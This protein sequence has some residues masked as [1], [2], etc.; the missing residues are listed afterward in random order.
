MAL[1]SGETLSQVRRN[2]QHGHPQLTTADLLGGPLPGNLV[3]AKTASDVDVIWRSWIRRPVKII[4]EYNRIPTK[5]QSA[6]LSLMGEGYAEQFE[7]VLH[8]GASSWFLTA[9][10]D[11][12]G[13][14]F[15]VIDALKDRIDALVRAVPFESSR[16]PLIAERV[17]RNE[18][19]EELLPEDL[20]LGANGLERAT[21]EVRAVRIAQPV[22]DAMGAFA[23]QLEFC[24]RASDRLERMTKD[25]LRVSGRRLGQ[26][27]NED[28]PLDKRENLCSQ[29]EFGLS[30][31]AHYSWL[32]YAQA[33]AWLEGRNEVA[34]EDLKALAPWVLHERLRPNTQ[35]GFF[36][37]SAHKKLLS[38]RAEWITQL[39]ESALEHFHLHEEDRS[40]IDELRARTPKDARENRELREEALTLEQRLRDSRELTGLL[41]EDLLRLRAFVHHLNGLAS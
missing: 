3:E 37:D 15:Q 39:F 4:D 26:V 24:Q 31:R 1:L 36:L 23:V 5:T 34:I 6:L 33:L 21:T 40:V 30:T 16:L 22:L 8:A 9:N 14:T 28:C 38:D 32:R 11:L 7:Q 27:C 41:H 25:T 18:Q 2:T 20:R 17:T 29:S 13:G 35:S 19:P 12:G 10:D